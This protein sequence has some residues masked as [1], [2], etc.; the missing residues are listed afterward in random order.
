MHCTGGAWERTS[1]FN[2]FWVFGAADIFPTLVLP[3]AMRPHGLDH[4]FRRANV[5]P[6]I[7]GWAKWELGYR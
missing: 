2:G 3:L 1:F 7:S 6:I 4:T 5:S